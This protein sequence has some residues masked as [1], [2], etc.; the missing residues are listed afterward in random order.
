MLGAFQLDVLDESFAPQTDT[1][2]RRA[3]RWAPLA[4]P[5]AVRESGAVRLLPTDRQIT[6]MAG[7]DSLRRWE[8]AAG[9]TFCRGLPAEMDPGLY[10][11][12]GTPRPSARETPY[13]ELEKCPQGH[14]VVC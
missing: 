3:L 11:Q 7:H 8:S 9:V 13:S 1:E 6:E 2:Q 12:E 5:Q 10:R 14:C 4:R